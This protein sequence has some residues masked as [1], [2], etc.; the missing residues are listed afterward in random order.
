MLEE[1]SKHH[2][3]LTYLEPVLSNPYWKGSPEYKNY[4]YAE[5]CWKKLSKQI[6]K[7]CSMRKLAA[8]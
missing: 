5:N 4:S 1:W 8:Q 6:G 3:H 2:Q 7:E